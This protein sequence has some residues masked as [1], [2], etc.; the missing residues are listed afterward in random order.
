M[1][2]G[3]PAVGVTPANFARSPTLQ[4]A[5]ARSTEVMKWKWSP[6]CGGH[7]VSARPPHPEKY[8]GIQIGEI[9][10]CL[11]DRALSLG[12]DTRCFFAE[13][14]LVFADVR[15]MSGDIDEG[16]QHSDGRRLL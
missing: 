12:E 5:Q 14:A 11:F 15:G 10:R 16:L 2:A 8:G 13:R 1:N 4:R 9:I 3:E 6:D 7:Y